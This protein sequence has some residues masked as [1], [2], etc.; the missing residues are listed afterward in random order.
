MRRI[1]ALWEVFVLRFEEA[2]ERYRKRRLTAEEAGELLGMSGRH[3]RRLTLRY[4]EDGAEGPRDRRLGRPSPRR[5]PAAELSR[6]QVL[7]Q[8]RYRDFTVKHFHEQLQK[9]HNYKLGYTV[10]RLALQGA[11]PGTEGQAARHSPQEARAPAAA[12]H[13]VVPGRLDTS[14]AGGSRP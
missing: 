2:L 7:Y 3:F 13:T 5:A 9:R 12:G 4:D 10:T 14:M 1:S 8:E 6:M 11:G